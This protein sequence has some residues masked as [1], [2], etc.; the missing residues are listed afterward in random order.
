MPMPSKLGR[1]PLGWR[2]RAG[3]ANP[4]QLWAG[5]G[6]YPSHPRREVS[7]GPSQS[8]E[9]SCINNTN[10]PHDTPA[11][12]LAGE[13]RGATSPDAGT[14]AG[15]E[16]VRGATVRGSSERVQGPQD[17]SAAES[18]R[19]VGPEERPQQRDPDEAVHTDPVRPGARTGRNRSDQD[20]AAEAVR[21]GLRGDP[22]LRPH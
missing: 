12:R 11:T 10:R 19:R 18:H 16:V 5:S 20:R 2:S 6:C 4:E 1:Q 14:A 22:W 15:V 7:D 13:P 21:G 3:R 17:S 9:D 8:Y